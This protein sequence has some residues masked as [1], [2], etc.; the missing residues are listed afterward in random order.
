MEQLD[1]AAIGQRIKQLR[2]AR[3][4]RQWQMAQLLGATQPAV[5]KYE[6]GILPEV[7]RLL[8]LARIGNTSVEWILTGR[9]WENGSTEMDR[10]HNAVFEHAQQ[11]HAFTAE[12]RQALGSALEVLHAASRTLRANGSRTLADMGDAEIGRMIRSFEAHVLE[13]LVAALSVY[14]AVMSTLAQARVREL[15]GFSQGEAPQVPVGDD[16]AVAV[17]RLREN[18]S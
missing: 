1:K 2:K 12:E 3:N 10:L 8:E 16:R 4:L 13:P 11:L 5:H 14:D 18:A 7:K 9:H 6:N 17:G 15:H